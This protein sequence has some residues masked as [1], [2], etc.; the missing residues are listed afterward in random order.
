MTPADAKGI[1]EYDDRDLAVANFHSKM[2]GAMKNENYASELLQV[3]DENG[4]IVKTEK[5]VR[6]VTVEPVTAETEE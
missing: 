4:K 5:Y 2:C 6:P 1:Y 3:I